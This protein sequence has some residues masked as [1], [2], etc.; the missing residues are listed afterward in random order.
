MRHTR[1]HTRN[2]R[3]H[4]A[5]KGTHTM[6]CPKCGAEQVRHRACAVCGVYR[7]RQVVDVQKKQAKRERKM[8]EK[9]QEKAGK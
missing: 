3:A 4:H 1:A 7:G 6:R 2:R 5:L 9:A 8:R